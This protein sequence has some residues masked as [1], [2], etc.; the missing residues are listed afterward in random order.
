MWKLTD[1]KRSSKGVCKDYTEQHIKE[2][3]GAEFVQRISRM[4]GNNIEDT[5]AVIIGFRQNRPDR[6]DYQ[7][8][9]TSTYIPKPMRCTYCQT[10]KH[11]AKICRISSPRCANCA[12]AKYIPTETILSGFRTCF[13]HGD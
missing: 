13:R 5:S 2:E 6:I 3:T 4:S 10:F 9:K 7:L 12:D 1:I 11:T 8:L